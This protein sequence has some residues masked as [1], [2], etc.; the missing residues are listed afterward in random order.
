ME[1]YIGEIRAVGFNFAPQNWA[2]CQGQI[3]Q[4]RSN[5]ALFSI[6]GTTYGGN[7]T[8]TFALPNLCGRAI[9]NAGQGP[10][11]ST[12]PRGAAVGSEGV[13]LDMTQIPAHIHSITGTLPAFN[14]QA[15]QGSPSNNFL[16][17]TAVNQYGEEAGSKTMGQGIIKGTSGPSGGG[18]A[19]SNM[20]PYLT[21]NYII[22]LVGVFP[23]RS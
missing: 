23:P 17:T 5:T 2:L 1:A 20:M 4:I 19:H 6:L 10:G 8:T 14:G 22:C 3:M 9:I 15:D 7:G 21:M 13:T 11:L 16:A 18:Q 12:Y